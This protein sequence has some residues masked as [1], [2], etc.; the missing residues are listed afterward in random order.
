M[1]NKIK[2]T[3]FDPSDQAAAWMSENMGMV[4]YCIHRTLRYHFRLQDFKIAP[5]PEDCLGIAYIAARNAFKFYDSTKGEFTTY[6]YRV[7]YNTFRREIMNDSHRLCD[8]E[9]N[10]RQHHR[11]KA[12]DKNIEY[13]SV[14]STINLPEF[15]GEEYTTTDTEKEEFEFAE[16]ALSLYD[17]DRNKLFDMLTSELD[18]RA[19]RVIKMRFIEGKKL[20]E[21]GEE[22]NL[23]RER[24][25]QIEEKSLNLIANRTVLLEKLLDLFGLRHISVA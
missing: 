9:H 25:R 18:S 17:G 1:T 21:A 15:Y 13:Y 7:Y 5:A 14:F 19:R 10:I 8:T 22:L 20:R 11:R 12:K 24:I 23:T 16:A 6:F 3:N 2:I 4:F